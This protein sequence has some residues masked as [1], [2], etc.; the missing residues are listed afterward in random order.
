MDTFSNANRNISKIYFLY[1]IYSICWKISTEAHDV[2]AR[3]S[4]RYLMNRLSLQVFYLSCDV[5]YRRQRRYLYY[6]YQI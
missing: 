1:T 5:M 4:H 2:L 3:L 6:G